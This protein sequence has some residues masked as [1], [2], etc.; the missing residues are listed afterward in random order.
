M[1]YKKKRKWITGRTT[2]QQCI[3]Q[4][5]CAQRKYPCCNTPEI[6]EDRMALQTHRTRVPSRICNKF[7]KLQYLSNGSAN[8]ASLGNSS[9][10]LVISIL[11]DRRDDLCCRF[12]FHKDEK[13]TPHGEFNP[14]IKENCTR[15]WA[16]V[17]KLGGRKGRGYWREEERGEKVEGSGG[18]GFELSMVKWGVSQICSDAFTGPSRYGNYAR[19]K[20][21]GTRPCWLVLQT[22]NKDPTTRRSPLSSPTPLLFL[23]P[24][25]F[26]PPFIL[27]PSSPATAWNIWG[28]ISVWNWFWS[29]NQRGEVETTSSCRQVLELWIR[30]LW[31]I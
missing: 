27:F 31:P 12:L 29:N 26:L 14:S 25:S 18:A 17:Q 11:R 3:L 30:G 28:Y 2:I 5:R 13:N 8:I 23:P 16:G 6:S 22:C 19:D 21:K 1:H 9:I 10:M 15:W 4:L 7:L 20:V 24:L